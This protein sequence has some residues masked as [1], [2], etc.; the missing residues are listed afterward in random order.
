[1]DDKFQGKYRIPSARWQ[2]WDYGWSGAYFITICTAGRQYLFGDIIDGKMHLSTIG[3]RVLMEWEKSFAIR[4]NLFCDEFVIMPNHI[5][6]ILRIENCGDVRG[7]NVHGCN[8]RGRDAQLCVSTKTPIANTGV[9]Y[10]SPKSISSFVACFKSTATKRCYNEHLIVSTLWQPRFRD[11]IIRNNA[12]YQRI[13][14]YIQ[15]NPQKW[16]SD[17]FY[18]L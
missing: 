12:E 1:M 4:P 17:R 8:A 7:G 10:R 11:H 15:N 18:N 13:A 16:N 5:H 9:A 6:A 14:E 2:H 3:E